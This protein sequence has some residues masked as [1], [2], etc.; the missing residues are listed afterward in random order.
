[1]YIGGFD[2]FE[3]TDTHL[4]VI[5]VEGEVP[6]LGCPRTRRTGDLFCER[7]E[8]EGLVE[9]QRR[10]AMPGSNARCELCTCELRVSEG[11]R[12]QTEG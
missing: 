10:I 5:T 7:G 6:R 4:L 9:V 2:S 3:T 8:A 12:R 1:M 11:R